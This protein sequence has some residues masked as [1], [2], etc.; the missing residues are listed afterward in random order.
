MLK[1]GFQ[2]NLKVSLP[3]FTWLHPAAV[4]THKKNGQSNFLPH[5]GQT[6]V[7]CLHYF[8]AHQQR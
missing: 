8:V 2:F 3:S 5:P 4:I 1:Y 7:Y 6:D